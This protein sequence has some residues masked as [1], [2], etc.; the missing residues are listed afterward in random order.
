[1]FYNYPAVSV[2]LRHPSSAKLISSFGCSWPNPIL[3]TITKMSITTLIRPRLCA[4]L[5]RLP[6]RRLLSTH[7]QNPH[8]VSLA[9]PTCAGSCIS[10]RPKI[11]LSS[12]R[13]RTANPEKV[14]PR[15]LLCLR[16]PILHA[17]PPLNRTSDRRARPRH[18]AHRARHAR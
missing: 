10:F 18:L 15:P 17:L 13:T 8:I 9:P 7:P 2:R 5:R 16:A 12:P 6:G 14:H 4:N 3:T 1:M 11:S